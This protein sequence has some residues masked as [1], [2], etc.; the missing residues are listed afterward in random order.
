MLVF[1]RVHNLFSYEK[2]VHVH[3]TI[4][5]YSN[6]AVRQEIKHLTTHAVPRNP[7]YTSDSG[8]TR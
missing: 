1:V 2:H 8:V 4:G 6:Y 5:T 3:G 7:I